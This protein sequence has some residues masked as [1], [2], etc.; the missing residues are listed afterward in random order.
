MDSQIYYY[1]MRMRSYRL[2][3]KQKRGYGSQRY[4]SAPA[5]A[6]FFF[7]THL[8]A[9]Q[10]MFLHIRSSKLYL[11][12]FRVG[13]IFMSRTRRRPTQVLVVSHLKSMKPIIEANSFG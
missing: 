6:G 13:D 9:L 11:T 5:F 8:Y 2:Q 10:C 7:L 1:Y 3:A 4:L 12:K